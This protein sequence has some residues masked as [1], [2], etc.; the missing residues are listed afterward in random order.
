MKYYSYYGSILGPPVIWCTVSDYLYYSCKVS[1]FFFSF[2]F[3]V[4]DQEKKGGPSKEA[5]LLYLVLKG[6]L[7]SGIFRTD[8]WSVIIC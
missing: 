4:T 1:R 3:L 6:L 7:C 5:F 8:S 2:F